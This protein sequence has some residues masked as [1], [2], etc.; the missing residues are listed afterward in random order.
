[1]QI[2]RYIL[3]FSEELQDARDAL[4]RHRKDREDTL[5]CLG[6]TGQTT[7]ILIG[8][9]M[10]VDYQIK[11]DEAAIAEL[12]KAQAEVEERIFEEEGE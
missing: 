11:R 6:H 8:S 10:A 2:K 7:A 3:D 5:A 9:L 1:M 4:A 12:E